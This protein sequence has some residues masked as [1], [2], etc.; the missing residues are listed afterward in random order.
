MKNNVVE[1]TEGER[2]AAWF[3]KETDKTRVL[4]EMEYNRTSC[5]KGSLFPEIFLWRNYFKFWLSRNTARLAHGVS[6][7]G[8]SPIHPTLLIYEFVSN[9]M[10]DSD[11]SCR[12]KSQVA[13][14]PTHLNICWLLSNSSLQPI[15]LFFKKEIPTK[16]NKWIK[17]GWV[18]EFCT[19]LSNYILFTV[20]K[21]LKEVTLSKNWVFDDNKSCVYNNSIWKA[22]RTGYVKKFKKIC[23]FINILSFIIINDNPIHNH[24]KFD[25]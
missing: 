6:H 22:L 10:T 9:N 13:N 15:I 25:T 18:D 11:G 8:H 23:M 12:V 1:E 24:N 7:A 19:F 2:C 16:R 14:I 4:D 3:S 5:L 21:S 17:F 20:N